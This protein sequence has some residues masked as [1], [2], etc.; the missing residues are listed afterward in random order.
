MDKTWVVT[1]AST[2]YMY[3][4]FTSFFYNVF[5]T[6]SR[7]SFYD[8]SRSYNFIIYSTLISQT[9]GGS[10]VTQKV[11]ECGIYILEHTHKYSIDS[12]IYVRLY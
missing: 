10:D 1:V 9:V 12:I 8:V 7:M 11:S 3:K 4:L 5:R 6:F 2:F